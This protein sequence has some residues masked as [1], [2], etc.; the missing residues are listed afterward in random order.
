MRVFRVARSLMIKSRHIS[1]RERHEIIRRCAG[2]SFAGWLCD[3]SSSVR[4]GASSAIRSG[5]WLPKVSSRRQ[6]ANR[7]ERHRVSRRW[8]FRDHLP[9]RCARGEVGHWRESCLPG[10]FRRVVAWCCTGRFSSLRSESRTNGNVSGFE[11]GSAKEIQGFPPCWRRVHSRT[12]EQLLSE[13]SKAPYQVARSGYGG[14]C[15]KW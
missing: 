9:K 13:S 2:D 1:T 5:K 7:N 6:Y 4:Q 8:V 15:G 14:S 12:A 10:A 11:A 3:F